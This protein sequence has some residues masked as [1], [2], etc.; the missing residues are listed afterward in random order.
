MALRLSS[1]TYPT[2]IHVSQVVPKLNSSSS[3]T[4]VHTGSPCFLEGQN[5]VRRQRI[6]ARCKSSYLAAKCSQLLF[7]RLSETYDLLLNKT[8]TK[9]LEVT[10]ALI[11]A[12]LQ[13][14][15]FSHS[16]FDGSGVLSKTPD[17]RM[18]LPRKCCR[19]VRCI[20]TVLRSS[21]WYV[22][23]ISK[24]LGR[25]SMFPFCATHDEDSV[26]YPTQA[27]F[28]VGS[29]NCALTASTQPGTA[30]SAN[31]VCFFFQAS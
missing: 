11:S 3:T 2:Y 9:A 1:L 4:H 13:R 26:T 14:D 25:K 29:P 15:R 8:G 20:R 22:F 17:E 12:G 7:G 5:H 23:N 24:E 16:V 18:P 21:I 10:L 19:R 27:Y 6:V 28:V 30:A 31:A